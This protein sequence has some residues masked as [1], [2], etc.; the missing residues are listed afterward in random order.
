M[1]LNRRQIMMLA[2]AV[3]AG[4]K[5]DA[6]THASPSTQPATT[7]PLGAGFDAGPVGEFKE[8]DVYT[9]HRDD[10]FEPAQP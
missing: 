3:V 9:E 6:D 4:C 8:D 5:R 1:A 10:G 2:T 7:E